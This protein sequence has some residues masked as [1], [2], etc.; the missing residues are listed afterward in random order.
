MPNERALSSGRS[1]PSLGKLARRS[2]VERMAA[3]ALVAAAGLLNVSE[4]LTKIDEGSAGVPN[5]HLKAS[6][7]KA[8]VGCGD[9]LI[10]RKLAA[11]RLL[12]AVGNGRA[13]CIVL[14]QLCCADAPALG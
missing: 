5:P 12:D 4:I 8:G 10:G 3:S 11:A 7:A 1:R 14:G 13:R 9:L 2:M 6:S